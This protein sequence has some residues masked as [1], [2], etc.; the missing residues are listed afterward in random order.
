MRDVWKLIVNGEFEKACKVTD[1]EIE[2]TGNNINL[3]NKIVALMHL[4]KYEDAILEANKMI[5][6]RNAETDWDFIISG[7]A[8]WLLNDKTIAIKMWQDAEQ[9]IYFDAAGGV[10]IQAYLYFASIKLNNGDLKKRSIDRLRKLLLEKQAADWP[11]PLAHYLL[12]EISEAELLNYA[13]TVFPLTP[14]RMCQANFVRAIKELE[15][16]A[17]NKYKEKLIDCIKDGPD[18]YVESMYYMA[19]GELENTE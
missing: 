7:I 10:D 12:D 19:K 1:Q 4:R 18:A 13:R 9:C 6:L 8:S 15:T 16:G 11:G 3:R 17:I 5:D 14:R 2:T